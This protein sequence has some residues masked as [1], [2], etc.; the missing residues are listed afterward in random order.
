MSDRLLIVKPSSLGDVLHAFPAVAALC[1]ETGCRADWLIHPAFAPLLRYLPCVDR[2][3]LFERKKLGAV[4]TFVPAYLELRREL[5]REKYRAVIDFQGLLRSAMLGFTASA[6]THAGV[7]HEWVARPFYG[8][9]LTVDPGHHALLRNNEAAAA[10]LGKAVDEIDFSFRLEPAAENVASAETLLKNTGIAGSKML[11]GVAPGARWVTKQWPPEF[12]AKVIGALSERY[13]E[14]VFLLLGSQSDEDAAQT[15]LAC[16][17]A[18]KAV[19]LCGKTTLGDLVELTRKC[20]LF[21]SNDSGPMHI[22]AALDVPVLA[23][24]GATSPVLTG[25][26]T[27]KKTVLQP[28]LACEQC[29]ERHCVKMTCHKAIEAERAVRAAQE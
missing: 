17:P 20:R 11:I 24:F 9:K 28:G 12:F 1:R 27:Q 22:A 26:Y 13:P 2:A 23:L 16:A 4:K 5:K 21:L 19:D 18:G 25:P 15:I 8:R 14:A 6:K 10:F 7:P 29:F 3:I